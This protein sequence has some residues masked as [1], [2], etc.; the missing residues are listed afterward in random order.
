METLTKGSWLVLI[1]VHVVPAL[2]LFVPSTAEKLYQVSPTGDVGLL[3]VHRG[4]L[5]L[6]LIIACVYAIFDPSLRRAMSVIVAVSLIGFLF[7]YWRGGMPS[8]ALRKLALVD[9]FALIPLAFVTF[10]AWRG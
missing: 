5:F 7:T 6:G 10:R 1:L 9:S 2:V 8:G 3:L 4:A